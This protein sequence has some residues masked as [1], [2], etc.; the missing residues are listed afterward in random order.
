[1]LP[2][3]FMLWHLGMEANHFLYLRSSTS[4]S[5]HKIWAYICSHTYS[6]ALTGSK[7]NN[8]QERLELV[9][10]WSFESS[11]ENVHISLNRQEINCLNS[12]N[13]DNKL[14]WFSEPGLKLWSQVICFQNIS[15][16][17]MVILTLKMV[18]DLRIWIP[19]IIMSALIIQI[20]KIF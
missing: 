6:W 5:E 3:F 9:S 20:F 11:N 8:K 4:L 1:M 16:F 17:G 12:W 2:I 13:L 10:F 18:Y 14:T 15:N 19:E 7:S